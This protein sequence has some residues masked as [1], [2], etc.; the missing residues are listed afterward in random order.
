MTE[1]STVVGLERSLL[2]RIVAAWTR[3]GPS[4]KSYDARTLVLG[5]LRISASRTNVIQLPNH[6]AIAS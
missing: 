5:G 6:E 3:T 1:S 2:D 4:S